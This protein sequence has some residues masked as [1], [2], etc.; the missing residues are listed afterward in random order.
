MRG[1]RCW[2]PFRGSKLRWKGYGFADESCSASADNCSA[3]TR[4]NVETAGELWSLVDGARHCSDEA[5]RT[6]LLDKAA[7]IEVRRTIHRKLRPLTVL[8]A[9]AVPNVRDPSSGVARRLGGHA[10]STDRPNSWRVVDIRKSISDMSGRA[11]SPCEG[12]LNVAFPCRRRGVLPADDGRFPD[13]AV[14]C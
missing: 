7:G 9:L 10:S 6:N 4:V 3:A 11:E 5:S 13:L 14:A 8:A 12:D 1:F 2:I